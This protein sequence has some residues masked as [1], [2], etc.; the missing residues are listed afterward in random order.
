MEMGFNNSRWRQARVPGGAVAGRGPWQPG[1]AMGGMS[2]QELAVPSC[3][4]NVTVQCRSQAGRL[5]QPLCSQ[6]PP[7]AWILCARPCTNS[8][9]L[10]GDGGRRGKCMDLCSQL[11]PVADGELK[12]GQGDAHF[13]WWQ[14]ERPVVSQSPL[15]WET[16]KGHVGSSR[17]SQRLQ[18]WAW[19]LARSCFTFMCEEK[20]S[21]HGTSWFLSHPLHPQRGPGWPLVQ[22]GHL[23]YVRSRR[24]LFPPVTS[25]A[26]TVQR[27]PH[28]PYTRHPWAGTAQREACQPHA[29][30][31]AA[32]LA[33]IPHGKSLLLSWRAD[34]AAPTHPLLPARALHLQLHEPL[35]RN[36]WHKAEPSLFIASEFQH[37]I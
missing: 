23:R 28:T 34:P 5:I 7:P 3:S 22:Y 15:A 25:K 26:H 35:L 29:P 17:H 1:G 36:G 16:P 24:R 12:Q 32:K 18:G 30:V 31:R 11:L 13:S 2:P 6:P 8:P 37:L 14:E 21:I 20:S 19:L 33:R 9:S 4:A 27:P 10:G